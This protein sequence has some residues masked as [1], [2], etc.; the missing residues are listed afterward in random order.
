M[1]VLNKLASVKGIRNTEPNKELASV[2]IQ[3]KDTKSIEELVGNLNHK[4]KNIQSDCIKVL[5]E[6]GEQKPELIAAYDQVFLDLL[7]HKNNRLVW[8]AMTALDCIANVKPKAMYAQLHTILDVANSG[9]IITKDHAAGILIKLSKDKSYAR[10][11]LIL[12]L[13]FFKTAATNQLPKYAEDALPVITENLKKDFIK[14]L[15]SRLDEFDKETKKVRLE[16][17][18]RKLTT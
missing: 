9:S 8:G 1:S 7:K 14:V 4:N 11:T 12:L 15:S 13:D 18:I 10:D 17:V 3:A 16:K 5:Y 2:I 6:I